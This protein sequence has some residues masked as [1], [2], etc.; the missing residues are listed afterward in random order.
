MLL[1][2]LLAFQIFMKL[3]KKRYTAYIMIL[4][5]SGCIIFVCHYEVKSIK[6][7]FNCV[8][9][10][11][12][13]PSDTQVMLAKSQR[14]GPL[15]FSHTLRTITHI[16][17]LQAFSNARHRAVAFFATDTQPQVGLTFLSEVSK[18]SHCVNHCCV[19]YSCS[20]P[21]TMCSCSSAE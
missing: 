4:T 11:E 6:L 5:W 8:L 14:H 15:A 20:S 19:P 16:V 13:V 17:S 1:L 7:L 9:T 18:I 12:P 2:T 3:E 10:A 21:V